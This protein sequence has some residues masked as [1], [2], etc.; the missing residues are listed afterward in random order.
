MALRRGQVQILVATDVAARGIDVPTITHVFNFGLP[1]KSRGLHPPHRPHRPCG[2]RRP[3][4]HV[5]RVP[6]SPQDRTS[7]S[8][9]AEVVAGLEPQQRM[10]Q[11]RPP[12]GEYRGGR[13]DNQSRDRK[14]GLV[15]AAAVVTAAAMAVAALMAA[16]PQKKA[17]A[18]QEARA[19]SLRVSEGA[20]AVEFD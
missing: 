11:S 19:F 1:M 9:K 15:Q 20:L 12:M 10:P 7:T 6:R 17:H 2:P 5:C 16:S 8:S 4:H 13:G 14:F 3:G 18:S